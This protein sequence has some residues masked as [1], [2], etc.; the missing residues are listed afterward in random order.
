MNTLPGIDFPT[1][2]NTVSVSVINTT[3]WAYDLPCT[4]MF[5]PRVTGLYT[6][7]V[8]S[9]AFLISHGSRHVL[10]DLGISKDWE[11]LVP[12]TVARLKDNGTRIEVAREL[13]DTLRDGGVDPESIETAIWSHLHWDHIGNLASFPSSTE[14]LVGPGIK[15]RFMPGWPAVSDAKFREAD[16]AGRRVTGIE[17]ESFNLEISGL[18]C[19]DYFGDG[20]F[21]LAH[22]P[23]HALGHLNALAR[24]ST[25][26]DT[27]IFLG[28]DGAHS[29]G[30]LRPN[31]ILPLPD[32]VDV[33]GITPRPC[34]AEAL[35]KFHPKKS[36]TLPYLGLHP[37]FSED[38][39]DAEDTIQSIQKFDADDRVLVLLAHDVSMYKILEYFPIFANEWKDKGWKPS[40][41]WAFLADL[42][43]AAST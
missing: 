10:F 12:S 34:P 43:S 14:L 31:E 24:T 19:H 41:R 29:G 7:N 37:D 30:E 16:V 39:Q 15:E 42:Q 9:Y 23:G 13:T 21:Y 40:A 26:A 35:L 1:S 28:A 17:A 3:S 32:I 11:N 27:F 8:C 36:R 4:K 5:H 20:S 22:A 18:K 38:L 25:N 33:P 6:L 2:N